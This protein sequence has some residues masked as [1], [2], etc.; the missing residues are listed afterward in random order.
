MGILERPAGGDERNV[1]GRAT[2]G[3]SVSHSAVAGL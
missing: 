3:A 1:T 2:L